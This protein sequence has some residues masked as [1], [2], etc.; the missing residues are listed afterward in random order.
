MHATTLLLASFSVAS[1]IHL[2]AQ[3]DCDRKDD[4]YQCNP[5]GLTTITRPSAVQ[6]DFKAAQDVIITANPPT[7]TV[8]RVNPETQFSLNYEIQ[9]W[10]RSCNVSQQYT[11][12]TN[13]QAHVRFIGST[14]PVLTDECTGKLS[15]EE[16]KQ[17][18]DMGYA[19]FIGKTSAIVEKQ[20]AFLCQAIEVTI[21]ATPQP[22]NRCDNEEWRGDTIAFLSTIT[23]NYYITGFN[24]PVL[25]YV[26]ANFTIDKN[27]VPKVPDSIGDFTLNDLINSV[28]E[29]EE[30][31]K[32][33]ENE[34]KEEKDPLLSWLNNGASPSSSFNLFV[35][36]VVGFMAILLCL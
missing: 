29:K 14:R 13:G 32:D 22:A 24:R 23:T 35:S 11:Y 21:A 18:P 31:P 34:E 3:V 25:D 6:F 30:A 2:A 19:S 12:Q 7:E 16:G 4:R 17:Y 1:G 9:L 36:T 5:L 10:T 33:K 15:Y 27:G 28:E 8:F 20:P 26:P